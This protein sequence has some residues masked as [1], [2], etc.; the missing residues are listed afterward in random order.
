[1]GRTLFELES[2][3]DE[4]IVISA[5]GKAGG[6]DA[7]SLDDRRI[8][9]TGLSLSEVQFTLGGVSVVV[10]LFMDLALR[11]EVR[12]DRYFS[13]EVGM[14]ASRHVKYGCQWDPDTESMLTINEGR[15]VSTNKM[16]SWEGKVVGIV[17]PA[18]HVA[19]ALRLGTGLS[20]VSQTSLDFWLPS[21][22]SASLESTFHYGLGNGI[23]FPLRPSALFLINEDACQ[24]EHEAQADVDL[25]LLW[26]GV[27]VAINPFG[28]YSLISPLYLVQERLL[29]A[30][31]ASGGVAGVTLDYQRLDGE[32]SGTYTDMNNSYTPGSA[33]PTLSPPCVIGIDCPLQPDQCAYSNT[34]NL[35]GF[36]CASGCAIGSASGQQCQP[37][38]CCLAANQ[39]PPAN[40]EHSELGSGVWTSSPLTVPGTAY[41]E[42]RCNAGYE[43]TGRNLGMQLLGDAPNC[44]SVGC[45]SSCCYPSTEASSYNQRP[46]DW[47]TDADYTACVSTDGGERRSYASKHDEIST[48]DM[49]GPAPGPSMSR[50]LYLEAALRVGAEGE[51]GGESREERL[52]TCSW[53]RGGLEARKGP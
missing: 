40:G 27:S 36:R 8:L 37:T 38:S 31:Y 51:E 16:F 46:G 33:P 49:D 23:L 3:I 12:T 32:S 2:W 18:I 11:L 47:P 41:T 25:Q 6:T 5:V 28:S 26:S 13:G 42:V 52:G 53:K 30:C 45:T 35:V 39:Y 24:V 1:M 20:A 29:Q 34:S 14:V 7:Q 15:G 19:V 10:G 9:H 22:L 4:Q 21:G 48:R 17:S 44:G 50:E 43:L